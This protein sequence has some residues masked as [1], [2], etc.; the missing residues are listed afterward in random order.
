MGVQT[1]FRLAVSR[2]RRGDGERAQR[3][4][5]HLG[6]GEREGKVRESKRTIRVCVCGGAH[7]RAAQRSVRSCAPAAGMRRWLEVK[8]TSSSDLIVTSFPY[9]L[10]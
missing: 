6:N 10:T 4:G 8:Y 2:R 7:T 9:S 5:S 1:A 3:Q